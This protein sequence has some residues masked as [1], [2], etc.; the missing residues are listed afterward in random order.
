MTRV[1][2]TRAKEDVDRLADRLVAAGHS[3]VKLPLLS[4]E[5]TAD[6]LAVNGF[7]IETTALIF[8]SVNAVRYGLQAAT[9]FALPSKAPIIAVGSRT[10]DALGDEGLVAAC[11]SREDS[12]GVLNWLTANSTAVTH[13]I[14]IKG[15]GGRELIASTLLDQGITVTTFDCYRRLWPDISC[16]QLTSALRSDKPSAIHVASGETLRR[17]SELCVL[18]QPDS[19]RR[20]HL[21]VP[22]RRVEEQ[23]QELGWQSRIVASGAGDD[24]LLYAISDLP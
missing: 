21:I 15:R 22:S 20:H 24:A 1:V 12:E 2:I 11:P 6:V 17:L 4:I 3:A 18:H 23:A 14:V 10:R 13:V 5:A 16:E 7:P 9:E 19:L 8:T